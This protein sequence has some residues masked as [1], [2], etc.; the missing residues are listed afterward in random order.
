MQ[1][2]QLGQI[3]RSAGALVREAQHIEDSVREKPRHAIWSRNMIPACRNFCAA[4]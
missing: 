2:E 4:H 3:V 1:H